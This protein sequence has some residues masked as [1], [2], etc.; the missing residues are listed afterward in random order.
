MKGNRY[1]HSEVLKNAI[2]ELKAM[3]HEINFHNNLIAEALRNHIDIR[4]LLLN[5]LDALRNLGVEISGTSSHGDRLCGA[6][7][8]RNFQIFREIVEVF[9][10]LHLEDHPTR[11]EKYLGSLT[12]VEAGLLYEA[13]GFSS[14]VYTTDSGGKLRCLI[15]PP[16][17]S[18]HIEKFNPSYEYKLSNYILTHPVWWNFLE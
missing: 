9:P 7:N 4:E 8:F 5:E 16:G 3:G 6:H 14:D 15:D 13:Y 10:S 11:I 17:W 2:K 1:I 12:M 18:E